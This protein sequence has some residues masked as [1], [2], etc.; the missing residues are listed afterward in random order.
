[1]IQ[2]T[3]EDSLYIAFPL[4]LNNRGDAQAM[5]AVQFYN[6]IPTQVHTRSPP[7]CPGGSKYQHC[8]I[9]KRFV[10]SKPPDYCPHRAVKTLTRTVL[11]SHAAMPYRLR[12]PSSRLISDA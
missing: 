12:F 7:Q 8:H 1:M 6:P 3:D 5:T 4:D 10:G 2:P 11:S 9:W